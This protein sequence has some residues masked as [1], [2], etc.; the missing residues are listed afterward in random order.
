VKYLKYFLRYIMWVGCCNHN[1]ML[2]YRMEIMGD[3]GIEFGV[4]TTPIRSALEAAGLPDGKYR[5]RAWRRGSEW[6]YDVV[7]RGGSATC[8]LIK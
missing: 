3:P 4:Q 8:R 2:G 1:R 5:I 7:L 6:I